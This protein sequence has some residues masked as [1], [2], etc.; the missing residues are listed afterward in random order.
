M[1]P[2][3]IHFDSTFP[4]QPKTRVQITQEDS[5]LVCVAAWIRL[6]AHAEVLLLRLYHTQLPQ[7]VLLT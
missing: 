7:P 2:L 3:E 4:I 6:T 1:G 5:E